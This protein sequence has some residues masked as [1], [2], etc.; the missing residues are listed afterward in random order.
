MSE[1]SHSPSTRFRYPD[2]S[3]WG[4]WQREYRYGALFIFPPPGIIEPIDE[5]RRR[6]D[7]AS[8]RSCQAHISLSEPLRGPLTED[9]LREITASLSTVEPF[10][11]RYGP[12]TVYAPYPGIAYAIEPEDQFMS[13]RKAVHSTSNFRNG[14]FERQDIPPHMTVAEFITLERSF[15]LQR[16]L[17]GN[18]PEGRF[19][20][21]AIEYAIPTDRLYFERVLSLPLG[22]VKKG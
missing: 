7:P 4:E 12:L 6:Y 8:A 13:L 16:E 22:E 17:S 2:T 18:V 19:L 14:P 11:I 21:D 10:E 15:E 1:G 9:H 3:G 20:C 5:L